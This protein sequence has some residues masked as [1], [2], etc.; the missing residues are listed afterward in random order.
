[1]L[2]SGAVIALARGDREL[3]RRIA[4]FERLGR[5]VRVPVVVFAETTRGQG[6]RDAAVNHVLNHCDPP[7]P[8]DERLARRAG[9]LLA[10]ARSQAT[11]DALVV[12]EAIE[13]QPAVI[14]TSD[15]DDLRALAAGHPRVAIVRV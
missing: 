5:E 13:M 8:L 10:A 3:R 7:R 15:P 14:F 2:D 4:N 9:A 6:P 1:M 11:I 12:A